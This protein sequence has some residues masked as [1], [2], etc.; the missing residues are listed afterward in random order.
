MN[1][2]ITGAYGQLGKEMERQHKTLSGFNFFFTDVDT[3]DITDQKAVIDYCEKNEIETIINCAAYTAVDLAED[4]EDKA[5]LV[6]TT[7]VENLGVA[8]QKVGGQVIH[9][10][11]DYVFD[12]SSNLPY[13]EDMP[14]GPVSAYGRSKLAGEIQLQDACPNSIVIRTAWLYSNYGKNFVKTMMSLGESRDELAVVFDQIG[15]PTNATD[16]AGAIIKILQKTKQDAEAFIPGVYHFSNEGVCSWYDFAL[17]VHKLA[18]IECKINPVRSAMFPTKAVRPAYSV[19]DKS[20]IKVTFGIDIRHW[21]D[22]LVDCMH[23]M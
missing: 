6:N 15:S 8:A 18:G 3:L 7:A 4:E 12:G 17:S 10:S 23:R 1:V 19:L 5:T 9:V 14:T 22:A 11:T 16:L 20:K 2:L 13:T 21:Y